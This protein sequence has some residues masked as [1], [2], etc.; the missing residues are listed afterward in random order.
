MILQFFNVIFIKLITVLLFH[1]KTVC[2][3]LLHLKPPSRRGQYS[4][5]TDV[6]DELQRHVAQLVVGVR[7]EQPIIN[8]LGMIRQRGLISPAQLSWKESGTHHKCKTS[9]GTK[10]NHAFREIYK[11]H[12]HSPVC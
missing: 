2:M 11:I 7:S 4:H 5:H 9:V 8:H 12:I 6:M 10:Q 1:V 3:R